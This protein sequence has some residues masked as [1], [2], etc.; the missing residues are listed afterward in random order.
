LKFLLGAVMSVLAPAAVLALVHGPMHLVRT[1]LAAA[2]VLGGIAIGLCILSLIVSG[3][4]KL[5]TGTDIARS[6]WPSHV[7]VTILAMIGLYVIEV[8]AL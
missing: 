8:S 6:W 5:I 3:V 7:S 4:L 2:A 1:P